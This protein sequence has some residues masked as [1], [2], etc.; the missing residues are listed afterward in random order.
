MATGSVRLGFT[1]VGG[2]GGNLLEQCLRMDDVAVPAV[3]DGQERHRTD[4]AET[5]EESGRPAPATHERHG[6]LVARDDLDGVVVATP[7]RHHIPMAVTAM[8]AGLDAA[9]EVGP[10]SSV[11]ECRELVRARERTGNHCMLLENCCY[12]RDC[13]A[14]LR[15]VREG[16]FGE[17]VRCEGGYCHDLR[18]RLVTGKET[19]V[20]DE[21][22]LDFRGVNHEKR[23]G[24]LYPTHSVGPMAKCLNINRGNRFVSLTAAAT[25]TAGLADW[26]DEHLEEDHPG[27][28]VDWRNGDVVT[29]TLT[30]AN[31]ETLTLTHDVSLPRPYSNRYLV[32]GTDGVWQRETESVHVEGRS[33]GHEWEPFEG[34][35]EEYEHPRWEQYL[36]EGVEEGHGGIDHLALR[37]YVESVRT[38]ER[39]PVD[40]YDAATWMAITPLSERALERGG[41]TDVPDFTDGAWL[42]DEPTFGV[43]D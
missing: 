10:A 33:P 39:P 36:E 28:D 29:T 26:A 2:R 5:V 41:A 34:Y 43:E 22:G 24:D 8:E 9:I 30:C 25:K 31:G 11:E 15:M 42:D 37:D 1:G 23:N 16:V 14:V 17:V 27:R 19:G 6:D 38:G 3:C 4:A 12:Y 18:E 32:Q 35:Q 7:W 13:M 40:A 20:E 21:S